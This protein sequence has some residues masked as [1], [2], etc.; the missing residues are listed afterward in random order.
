MSAYINLSDFAE[1]IR[2]RAI[3][4]AESHGGRYLAPER[5]AGERMEFADHAQRDA[6]T[7]E[8]R[9]LGVETILDRERRLEREGRLLSIR[10]ADERSGPE[11]NNF[12]L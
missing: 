8:I 2:D 5:F 12:G 11:R 1:S 9:A 3:S 10:E 4:I 7:A 6:A